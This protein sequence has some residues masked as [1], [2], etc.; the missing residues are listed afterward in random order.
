M[1]TLTD[2]DPRATILSLDGV[3]AFDLISRNSMMQGLLHMEGVEKLL[4]FVSMFYSTPSTFLWEDEEGTV[5][6]IL[7]GEGG[8]QGNPLMSKL[9]AVGQHSSLVAVSDRLRHGER[10]C[11][12]LDDLYVASNPERT[13]DCHQIFREELWNHAK[14][15][16]HHGRMAVWNRG[17]EVPP[18]I[19]ALERAARLVD[20][21]ARV[22]RGGIHS[23]TEERGITTLGAPVCTPEFVLRQLEVKAA[24]HQALLQRIPETKDLQCAWL[25]LLYFAAVRANFFIRTVSPSLSHAFAAQHERRS[26]VVFARWLVWIQEPSRVPPEPH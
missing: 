14:I 18:D 26:G 3:G 13:V 21:S 5:H 15:R 22:W 8:E 10:L 19:R 9:L 24:E 2:L 25:V 16:L 23:V 17:R 20:P 1:Q 12:F 11:A 6:V 4:P 7:Q